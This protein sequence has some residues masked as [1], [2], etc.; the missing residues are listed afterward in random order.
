MKPKPLLGCLDD[1]MFNMRV[2][3]LHDVCDFAIQGQGRL[4]VQAKAQRTYALNMYRHQGTVEFLGQNRHR[5]RRH[6]WMT[7]KVQGHAF[8]EFLIHQQ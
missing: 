8:F 7:H 1:P 2:D 5:G 6:S 4:N 3:V